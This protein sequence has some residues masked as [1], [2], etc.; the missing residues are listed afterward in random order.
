[1]KNSVLIMDS[2]AVIL[3][4]LD[5]VVAGKL[6]KAICKYQATGQ[7][8]TDD[9]TVRAILEG[10]RPTID[11]NNATY[12]A[13][14]ERAKN[15]RSKKSDIKVNINHDIKDDI[16]V[17]IKDDIK[18]VSDSVS[19]SVSSKEDINNVE[20]TRQSESDISEIVD[21]LNAKTQ[22]KFSSKT[23]A[24]RKAIIARLKEGYT[25]EDFKKVIDNKV[26][27]WTDGDMEKYLRP[28]TLF[29]PSNFEAYLNESQKPRPSNPF[30]KFPQNEYTED[31]LERFIAN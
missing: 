2:W 5:D 1:M 31:D 24:T 30:K 9:N 8:E 27:D 26:S 13:R 16:K 18:S 29:R 12:D 11:A 19:V 21:Y 4:N 20:Q 10:W 15:A 14:V 28:Q 7:I 23:A 6:I 17:D 25:V 3:S 22:K